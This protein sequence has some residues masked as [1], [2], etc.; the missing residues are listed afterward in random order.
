MPNDPTDMTAYFQLVE[1][2]FH[3][4]TIDKDLQL[5]IINK[6]LTDD[7]RKLLTQTPV[8]NFLNLHRQRT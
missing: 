2:L 3:E 8:G 4:N 7:S 5:T 6:Y 1:R